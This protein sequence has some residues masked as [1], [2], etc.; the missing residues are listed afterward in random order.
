[1]SYI[2][3]TILEARYGSGDLK[4]WTDDDASGSIDATVVAQA[5]AGA[6][7]QI[8]GAAGQQY[9]TPLGLTDSGTAALVQLHAGSIAGYL[10]A[11]RRPR[12]VPD[13]IRTQYEDALAW[14]K[15]LAA[16]KVTLVGESAAAVSRPGGGIVTGG[17][18]AT[19]TRDTMDGL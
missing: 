7:A 5:I 11:S 6:E 3:Q 16:G 17:S 15:E 19:I 13:N 18:T 2:T 12:T 1:M 10:L 8:N 4:A 9:T 14:L